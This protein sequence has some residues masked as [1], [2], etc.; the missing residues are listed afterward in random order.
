M[1][2]ARRPNGCTCGSSA[3]PALECVANRPIAHHVLE[4]LHSAGVEDMVLVGAADVLIEV[5][6]CLS[7]YVPVSR[8]HYAVSPD[9]DPVAALRAA[10]G[11]IGGAPCIVHAGDGLLNEPLRPHFEALEQDS[12]DVILV[13]GASS[14]TSPVKALPERN[15]AALAGDVGIALFGPGVLSEACKVNGF[16]PSAGLD[17]LARRLSEGGRTVCSYTT[18][19]W[20]RYTGEPSELLE[21]NRLALDLLPLAPRAALGAENRI[22]GRVHIDPTASV[23]A[24]VIVGP[25]VVG[26]GAE[27][28]NAY[29]GPYTSIGAGATI[30]GAEIERSIIAPGATVM[31]VGARLV[32][33]LVGP[34]ARVCRDFSLPRAV[35]L[36]VGEAD[37]VVLC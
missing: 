10:G 20:R 27:V 28:S 29:I 34:R 22:E 16:K 25:V 13:C 37:E 12:A 8:V 9:S 2:D 5:R 31:H 7:D 24:S 35:R 23:T 4:A 26:E 32:S 15:G 11:L 17:Q 18:E 33:S 3:V 36:R 14:A 19:D 30:E 21:V 6:R 1:A